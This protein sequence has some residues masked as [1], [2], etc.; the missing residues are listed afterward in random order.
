MGIK[1][2][3]Q[4]YLSSMAAI[5]QLMKVS[6]TPIMTE[7]R[8]LNTG[9]R[10]LQMLVQKWV[11]P[12]PCIP[13]SHP[14]FTIQRQISNYHSSVNFVTTHKSVYFFYGRYTELCIS[15]TL[16]REEKNGKLQRIRIQG[17]T[18]VR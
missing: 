15:K 5:Y 4:K 14:F 18:L 10:L 8:F 12:F 7:D 17:P 1:L 13:C 16:E 3:K 6:H 2:D 9:G 11:T